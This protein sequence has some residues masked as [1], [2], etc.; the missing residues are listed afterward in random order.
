MLK[1][2]STQV[3]L[4]IGAGL[5]ALLIGATLSVTTSGFTRKWHWIPPQ[6]SMSVENPAANSA[7]P[8]LVGL[9]PEQRAK[10][11]EAIAQGNNELDRNRAR[12]LLASDLIRQRQGEPALKW[13][14]GLESDYSAL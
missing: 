3:S 13:I 14:A 9:S 7:I 2:R 5:C 10:K 4:A 8:A 12:Y 1:Q 6:S 11:L